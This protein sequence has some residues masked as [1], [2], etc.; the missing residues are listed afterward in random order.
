[1]ASF[2]G[3]DEMRDGTKSIRGTTAWKL[4]A[5]SNSLRGGTLLLSL[6]LQF[7]LFLGVNS[8]FDGIFVLV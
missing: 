7:L 1:M 8:L 4:R 5:V 2:E 6:F 3:T